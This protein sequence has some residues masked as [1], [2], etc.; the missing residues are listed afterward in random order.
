MD[1]LDE[2]DL[3]TLV[4]LLNVTSA[5][6]GMEY[7]SRENLADDDTTKPTDRKIAVH[8]QKLETVM[9]FKNLGAIISQEGSKPEILART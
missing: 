4:N 7:Q 8:G 3:A 6:Y 2:E 5:R 1:G 9:Q